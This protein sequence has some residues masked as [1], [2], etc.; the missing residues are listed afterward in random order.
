MAAFV[1]L[2]LASAGVMAVTVAE[3]GVHR[4]TVRPDP[5][6]FSEHAVVDFRGLS[7]GAIERAADGLK[8]VAGSRGWLFRPGWYV[9]NPSMA[10]CSSN[11]KA[12]PVRLPLS[13]DA[14]IGYVRQA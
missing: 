9:P 3:C 11:L 1:D 10:S 8:T 6:S 14:G 2:Y 4:L 7:R 5:H 12:R 13:G